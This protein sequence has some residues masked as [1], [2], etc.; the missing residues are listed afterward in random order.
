MPGYFQSNTVTPPTIVGNQPVY[1]L[2]RWQKPGDVK[3]QQQFSASYPSPVSVAYSD[4]YQST[5]A[6]SDASYIRLKNFSFG[7]RLPEKWQQAIH[8]QN[9]RIYVQGQNLLT[10]THY[11]GLDPEVPS[12]YPNNLPPLRVVTM[13]V[14]IGL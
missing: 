9:S 7:W 13:G 12:N 1:V 3:P 2:D 5:A 14:Q 6:F 10:I 4:V 8:I 11:K